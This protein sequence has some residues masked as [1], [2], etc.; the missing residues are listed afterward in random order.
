MGCG[1]GGQGTAAAGPSGGLTVNAY[2]QA[3]TALRA[4]RGSAEPQ[5]CTATETE[6][7]SAVQSVR[8]VF[9][10]PDLSCCVAVRRIDGEFPARSLVL[11]GLPPGAATFRVEG[12]ETAAVPADG[13]RLCPL[14]AD[15]AGESCDDSDEP[16]LYGTGNEAVTI[17]S[18]ITVEKSVSLCMLRAA[19]TPTPT[20]TPTPTRTATAT[21]TATMTP[22]STPTRTPTPSSTPTQTATSTPTNT[23]TDT[24]TNTP[25]DTPTPTPTETDTPTP[26]ATATPSQTATA[27]AT[28]TATQTP[29]ATPTD[30]PTDTPTEEAITATP[31]ETP[32]P[33]PSLTASPTPEDVIIRI[34]PE[35]RS[36]SPGQAVRISVRLG[37][38][39]RFVC[40]TENVIRL[41]PGL[42]I[43]D[44]G[45]GNPACSVNPEI[46]KQASLFRFLS[47]SACNPGSDCEGCQCTRGFVA[48][49][50]GDAPVPIPDG[51]ELYGCD[52]VVAEDAVV[53]AEIDLEC[54]D[55]GQ[56]RSEASVAD[57]AMCTQS[58]LVGV[59]C[60]GNVLTVTE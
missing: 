40:A 49:G 58:M 34:E 57:N 39:G 59:N 41:Q 56:F 6:V 25:T 1:G 16:P 14:R 23:P 46:S 21:P 47:D 36:A 51:M 20:D 52:A 42:R 5:D 9:F 8:V 43:A 38:A 37:T 53:G 48:T 26:T 24:P 33:T 27:T 7:P 44:D 18:G 28:E 31:T 3:G 32:T 15:S 30:T 60:A 11:G 29:T 54:P 22:T 55:L 19:S 50:F 4:P 35:V 17:L 10:H 13:L 45:S 2:W 12:F